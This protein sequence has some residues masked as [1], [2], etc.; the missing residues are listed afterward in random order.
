LDDIKWAV[1]RSYVFSNFRRVP[2]ANWFEL[3]ACLDYDLD[4][5][6]PIGHGQHSSA[7]RPWRP[8]GLGRLTLFANDSELK[9]DNNEGT[10]PVGI[11]RVR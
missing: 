3:V 8:D 5:A 9:Y 4:T 6:A 2:A 10:M 11:R 7:E 1:L